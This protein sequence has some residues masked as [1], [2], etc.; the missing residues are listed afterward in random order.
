MADG[1]KTSTKVDKKKPH[2]FVGPLGVLHIKTKPNNI[3][4]TIADEKGNVISWSTPGRAGFKGARKS[5]I[6]AAQMA[7]VSA[8]KQ[9]MTAGIQK[10]DVKIKGS[11]DRGEAVVQAVSEL[12]LEIGSVKVVG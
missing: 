3:T 12:G 8:A 10:V 7:G 4:V 1:P 5:T 9:A 6:M 2:R 11:D